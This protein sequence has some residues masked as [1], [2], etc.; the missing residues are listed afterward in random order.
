MRSIRAIATIG[1]SLLL[2]A[3]LAAAAAAA[4]T[5]AGALAPNACTNGIGDRI[6]GRT[7]CIHV[8]GKCV[9]SHNARYR[10]H[11]YTCVNGRL[12]RIRKPAISVG[13]ASVPEGNSGSTT[14]SVLVTLSA[15]S[16]SAVKVSY[17]TADGTANAGSDYTAANGTIT[18]APGEKQKT[19]S[20]SV[21]GDRRIEADETFSVTLSSPVNATIA[22]GTSTVTI[23]NDDT[24]AAVTPGSYKGSTQN[25]NYVF[26]TVGADRTVTGLRLNDLS[27][28]CDPGGLR[29]TGGS[30][31]GSSL[32]HIG[33]DGSFSAEGTWSGSEQ[34]GDTE[35]TYWHANVHGS[36]DNAT[37]VSGTITEQYELNYKGQHFKCTS[38]EIKW[39]A[40][41]QG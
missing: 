32:F 3:T 10:A 30:D 39:S 36:F 37:S 16:T 33:D 23:T 34:Q 8:G 31:F 29:L 38:G 40:T 18:F 11:G 4:A 12:R 35:W 2:V 21:A 41:R 28:T 15:S 6:G 7:V 1:A 14:V 24:A 27:E 9:A 19:I 20:I 13:D 26:F 25:G 17:A 5:R 22:K